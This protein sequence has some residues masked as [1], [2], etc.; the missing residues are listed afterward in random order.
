ML[1]DSC[2]ISQ[3]VQ[4][5]EML[6]LKWNFLQKYRENLIKNKYMDKYFKI[7]IMKY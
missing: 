2:E 7:K 3:T 1:L 5:K 4:N 6:Y